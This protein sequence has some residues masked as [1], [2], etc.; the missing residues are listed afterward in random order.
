MAALPKLY[1]ILDSDC[2][3]KPEDI[4]SFTRE[5]LSAGVTLLQYRNKRGNARL[6]LEQ[7]RTIK[8]ISGDSAMLMMNDRPDLCLVADFN[9]CHVGQDDLSPGAARTILGEKFLLGVSTH[10]PEQV[11]RAHSTSADYIAVGPVFQTASKANPDPVVGLNGVRRARE[12]TTKPLVAIGGITRINCREVI[13]AGADCVAVIADLLR[14]PRRA[15]AEF[16]DLLA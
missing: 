12:L 9:G 16:L 10:N 1:A 4:Y 3:S 5:L 13:A 14:E 11:E 7:A 15:A 6:M 8:R 2:F